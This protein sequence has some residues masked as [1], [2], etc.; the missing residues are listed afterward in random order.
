MPVLDG[1]WASEGAPE[2]RK[3]PYGR[4]PRVRLFHA[5]LSRPESPRL[6]PSGKNQSSFAAPA[7]PPSQLVFLSAH[8]R[9]NP[10]AL[11]AP[12][13]ALALPPKSKIETY[14]PSAAIL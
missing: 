1:H 7:Q 9:G 3:R 4:A 10:A 13:A 12:A 14:F 2:R 5:A 8:P 11:P 6:M